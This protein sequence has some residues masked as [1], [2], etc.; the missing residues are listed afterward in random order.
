D[1]IAEMTRLRQEN[2][3]TSPTTLTRDLDKAVESAILRCLDSDPKMRPVTA[4]ALSAML[5]GG[6]PLAAALADGVTPSPEVV[7]AAGS[8]DA[9][10]PKVAIPVLAGVI[11]GLIAFC[12]AIPRVHLM[13]LVPLENPPEVL[14]AKARD[15][16]KKLGYTDRAADWTGNFFVDG[17]IFNFTR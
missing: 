3:I 8:H 9:L 4:M 17:G 12:I 11:I 10:A 16:L 6:D 15:V 7:A 2:R 13:N 1:T 14:A 5:P